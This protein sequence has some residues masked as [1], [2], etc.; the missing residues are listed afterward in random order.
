MAVSAVPAFH[1]AMGRAALLPQLLA[2]LWIAAALPMAPWNAGTADTATDDLY[3]T[4][5]WK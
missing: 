4:P 2:A 5:Q 3:Y 1:G